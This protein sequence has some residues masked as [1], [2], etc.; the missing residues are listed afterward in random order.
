M[1]IIIFNRSAYWHDILPLDKVVKV[2]M[3]D[4]NYVK[5]SI[6]LLV[7]IFL[8]QTRDIWFK[9]PSQGQ[10][11][12]LKVLLFIFEKAFSVTCIEM[13]PLSHELEQY[14]YSESSLIFKIFTNYR[15]ILNG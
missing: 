15:F 2:V 5:R 1:W 11:H 10:I 14:I 4:D 12:Y 9:C 8:I 3:K 13:K 6:N 7:S